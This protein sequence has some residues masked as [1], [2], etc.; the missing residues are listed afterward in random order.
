MD[1][2]ANTNDFDLVSVGV[3]LHVLVSSLM[4]SLKPLA[5]SDIKTT[6]DLWWCGL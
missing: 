4:S 2:L 1:V 3:M 5:I 6:L